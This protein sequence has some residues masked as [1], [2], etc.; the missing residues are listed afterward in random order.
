MRPWKTRISKQEAI[1]MTFYRRRGYGRSRGYS[2]RSM[3][4]GRGGYSRYSRGGGYRSRFSS[5][6]RRSGY[7]RRL[8]V[9]GRRW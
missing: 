8:N 7:G 5:P 2:G 4:R 3:F 9:A 1:K 6:R